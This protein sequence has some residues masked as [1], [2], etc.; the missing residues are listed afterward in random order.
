MRKRNSLLIICATLLLAVFLIWLF[1]EKP[2]STF[3]RSQRKTSTPT[4]EAS[5]VPAIPPEKPTVSSS[6]GKAGKLVAQS[7]SKLIKQSAEPAIALPPPYQG[8]PNTY[9]AYAGDLLPLPDGGSFQV[10][11]TM[12]VTILVDSNLGPSQCLGPKFK[13][14][15]EPDGKS[16][17]EVAI[18]DPITWKDVIDHL[19]SGQTFLLT[20]CQIEIPQEDGSKQLW[21]LGECQKQE[22]WTMETWIGRE[23]LAKGHNNHA[24]KD[25]PDCEGQK[26]YDTS[27]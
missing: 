25:S 15:F 14:V 16:Y 13:K 5:P 23:M 4:P 1:R 12:L 24:A 19:S 2:A 3:Q 7:V 6:Q 8:R 11:A 17:T 22:P 20:G 26:I 10:P 18:A 27:H 21:A 9:R